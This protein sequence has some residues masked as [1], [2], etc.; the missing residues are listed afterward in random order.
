[1][2][3]MCTHYTCLEVLQSRATECCTPLQIFLYY[4]IT[5]DKSRYIICK[6]NLPSVNLLLKWLKGRFTA[7]VILA[8]GQ[9]SKL[10]VVK[11]TH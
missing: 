7:F 10:T 8:S 5:T 1:M 6:G 3:Q 4:S 9:A 11:L 2:S